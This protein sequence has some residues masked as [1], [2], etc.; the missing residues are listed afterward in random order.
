VI[1][2]TEF[3]F[4]HD[5]FLGASGTFY[6]DVAIAD[7][8]TRSAVGVIPKVG[9]MIVSFDRA[10]RIEIIHIVINIS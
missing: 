4:E 2:A 5:S 7:H 1:N 9:F 10:G 3:P 6:V 8:S